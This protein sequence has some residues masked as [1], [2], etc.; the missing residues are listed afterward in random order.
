MLVT[1]TSLVALSFP[2]LWPD[3]SP[4]FARSSLAQHLPEAVAEQRPE[5]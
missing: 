3:P 2:P 4:F 1:V 5:Q